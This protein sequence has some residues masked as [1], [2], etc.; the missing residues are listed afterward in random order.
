MSVIVV[1][2][3]LQNFLTSVFSSSRNCA[4][5]DTGD[6]AEKENVLCE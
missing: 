3:D 2:E 6:T 4:L 1:L 5:L